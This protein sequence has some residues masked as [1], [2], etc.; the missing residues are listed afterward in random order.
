MAMVELQKLSSFSLT[1]G[2]S[3][4][5]EVTDRVYPGTLLKVLAS[6][7]TSE[8]KSPAATSGPMVLIQRSTGVLATCFFPSSKFTCISAACLERRMLLKYLGRAKICLTYR[9]HKVTARA[10][11]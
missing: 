8:V 5:G 4:L 6:L 11:W 9:L 1:A 10:L 2:S 7:L 3:E